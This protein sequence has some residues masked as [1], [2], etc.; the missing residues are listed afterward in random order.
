MRSSD[1]A[2]SLAVV[3]ARAGTVLL[4]I[5]E[6]VYWM[7]H[8]IRRP[9]NFTERAGD[10]LTSSSDNNSPHDIAHCVTC[11]RFLVL[12]WLWVLPLSTEAA[13]AKLTATVGPQKVVFPAGYHGLNYF[14]DEPISIINEKPYQFLMTAGN[15]TWLMQGRTL[16]SAVPVKQVLLPGN[17]SEF[18]NGY[19]GITSTVY[20]KVGKR[21]L[22]FYHAEDHV[23]MPKVSY[24]KDIQGAYWSIG[25]A[26]LNDGS[27]EFTKA[28]QILSPSVKKADVTHDHQGIGD[29][30]VISDSANVYLYAYFTDLTRKKGSHPA[31]IGMA[32]CRIADVGRPGQWSKYHNGDFTES[33]LGGMESPVVFPPTAFPCDVYAPHVTYVREIRKYVMVCNVMVYSDHEKQQA[34]KGGIYCCFS[35]NGIKWSEPE[36][37]VVG[38]PVPYQG[39]KYVAHPHLM[40]TQATANRADGWL[41]H[42]YTPRWGTSAPNHPHHLAKRSITIS[43][44]EYSL[45]SKLAGTKW[46]N[47]NKVTFEWTKGGRFLH[48]QVE[49]EWKVL[50]DRRVQIIF[51]P[52]H[53]DILEFDDGLKTFKQLIRGGASSFEG[54]RQ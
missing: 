9:Q 16:E 38:H 13:D 41:L 18:D 14:P 4:P 10:M 51:S 21:L 3:L 50:D 24:N 11:L 39:R 52:N 40:I 48:N 34:E 5:P 26:V 46:V 22:A 35:D 42:C 19:S 53:I 31:K 15:S 28:G 44:Q 47:S 1:S 17:K 23:G 33:G 32:R 20:D 43:L 8:K 45:E 54:R 6:N 7:N 2:Y 12:V 29:V 36:L 27:N 49:R 37:L 25:I 30:C